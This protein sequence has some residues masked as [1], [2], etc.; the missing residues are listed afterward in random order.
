MRKFLFL[1]FPA[2]ATLAIFSCSSNDDM[3]CLSCNDTYPYQPPQNQYTYCLIYNRYYGRYECEYM[4]VQQCWENDGDDGYSDNTCGGYWWRSIGE[5]D[6][7]SPNITYESSGVLVNYGDCKSTTAPA[8][9]CINQDGILCGDAVAGYIE[10]YLKRCG[11]DEYPL[12]TTNPNCRPTNTNELL[13][14]GGIRINLANGT[15]MVDKNRIAGLLVDNTWGLYVKI[16]KDKD[17]NGYIEPL[18]VCTF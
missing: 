13:C 11:N 4:Q 2:L 16:V 7:S 9:I 14:Y 15:V 12:T 18:K 17:P 6:D 1:L 10:F 8:E 3:P 5:C